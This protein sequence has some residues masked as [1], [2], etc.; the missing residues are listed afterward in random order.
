M[1]RKLFV[2]ITRCTQNSIDIVCNRDISNAIDTHT[3]SRAHAHHCWQSERS[4]GEI[5]QSPFFRSSTMRRNNGKH[6]WL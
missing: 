4:H 1:K 5:N 2:V 6:P 3:H